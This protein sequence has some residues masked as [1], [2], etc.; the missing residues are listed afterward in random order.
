MPYGN[1][2]CRPD[3][4]VFRQAPL[5]FAGE[6]RSLAVVVGEVIAYALSSIAAKY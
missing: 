6:S 2:H 5:E 3:M 1:T 4:T